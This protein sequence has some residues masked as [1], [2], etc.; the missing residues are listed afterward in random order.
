MVDRTILLLGC[1]GQLGFELQK[2]LAPFGGV[3]ARD[4]PDID[5][6]APE[7]LR[8]IVREI[9]PNIVVNAAAY[10]AVDKAESEEAKAQTINAISPGVLAEEANRIGAIFVH[11]STD[12]VFDGT[13]RDPYVEA[14]PTNPL[15]VY[16]RTKRD[17]ELAA[18][19]CCKHLIF[20]T[21]WVVGAHGANFVKTMLRLAAERDFI[22]VVADQFGAPTTADLLA[23][24]TARILAEMSSAATTDE[25]WG[26]YHL[27]AAGETSW[28]GLARRIMARAALQSV[29]LKVTPDAVMEITTAEYPTPAR[30]PTNS[31]L[32]TTK[33]RSTF[34]LALPDWTE[35]IDNVLNQI[36]GEMRV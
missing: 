33:L 23:C 34:G 22:R 27:V 1:N 21:S 3:V 18:S 2:S 17:G 15:S 31:R 36:L 26:L 20:R 10:T 7:N 4:Y 30:R 28:N 29:P 14:D 9:R 8:Q 11:Y 25:R 6:L 32:D 5:F 16:G 12:Y 24:T 13:K 19:S 35:G